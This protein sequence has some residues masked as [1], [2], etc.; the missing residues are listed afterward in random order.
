VSRKPDDLRLFVAVPA[1]LDV[2]AATE[3]VVGQLKGQ[4]DVRWVAPELLHLTL[5]FLGPTPAEKVGGI[6]AAL[7]EKANKFSRFMVELGDAGAFPNLRRPQTIWMGVGGDVRALERL[8]ERVEQAL[9]PLGFPPEKRGF[10]PHL[11][12]GRVKSPKGLAEL[13]RQLQGAAQQP[14]RVAVPWPVE[15]IHLVQSVL[16]PSGPEYT[17]L[18]VFRLGAEE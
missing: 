15:E 18:G 4:G 10:R 8:A 7:A 1:P 6:S 16:K 9:E 5:K 14:G 17:P 3:A 2:R 12:I 11:T 13:S